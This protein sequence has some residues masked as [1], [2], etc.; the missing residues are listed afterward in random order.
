MKT[1]NKALGGGIKYEF[2]N[3]ELELV[4]RI[5]SSKHAQFDLS[6]VPPTSTVI[7]Q[8]PSQSGE[9]L[10]AGGNFD[11]GFSML[12]NSTVTILKPNISATSIIVCTYTNTINSIVVKETGSLYI[13]NIVPNVS[14]TVKSTKQ[15]DNNSF[16][17]I[18]F[19]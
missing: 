16:Y 11:V 9:I 10:T 18:I 7:L 17:Y 2:K 12:S 8:M 3:D 6:L 5:D 4:D 1:Y 19:Y 15:N 13:D 14:F